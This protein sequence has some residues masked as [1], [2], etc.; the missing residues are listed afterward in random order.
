MKRRQI[1][2]LG[3]LGGFGLALST[4]SLTAEETTNK[5]SPQESS[6]L[7]RFVALG[8]VG[9]GNIGQQKIADVMKEYFQQQ[10]FVLVLLTGDN[11]YE[12]GEIEKVGATF[13]RPY[14]FLRQKPIPFYAVLGNH[15]VRT[16]NG[17]DQVNYPGFNMQGRYYTFSQGIVQ[18]FALDTNRKAEWSQQLIW[19]E[20]NLAA[21]TATWK[22]VFG[23]HPLYSSG[24]HGTDPKRIAKLCPLFARYGVQL[25]INGHDH[26]YERTE[27]IEGTTYLTCGA[28]ATTRPVGHSEWTAY[29][30]ARL[31]FATIDVYPQ[32]LE[33]QGIGKQGEV[34]DRGKIII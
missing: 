30:A 22:I 18:F 10:P 9:R 31:S 21:S 29:S 15:D 19:L 32:H 23:H 5:N 11:I 2:I 1:L 7:F 16:N 26:N 17:V 24:V 27:P 12:N 34:F 20:K 33:I 4:H 3:A 14:R 8:D 28:G 13:E 6:S 25:Y